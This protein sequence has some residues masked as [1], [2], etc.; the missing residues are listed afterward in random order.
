VITPLRGQWFTSQEDNKNKMEL[1]HDS[2]RRASVLKL[3]RRD[4]L[5]AMLT[6]GLA[7]VM[8]ST[9]AQATIKTGAQGLTAGPVQIPVA[10]RSIPA[11]RALP[12]TGKSFPVVLVV[13]EIYGVN[14]HLCDVCRRLAKLGYLAIAPQL[15]ARQ[16][17]PA[18]LASAVEIVETIVA[19]VPDAQVMDDLDAATT[20]AGKNGGDSA[21]LGITGCG[22]GGRI[23]W[24]YAAHNPTLKAGVA[25]YGPL[26]GTADDLRPKHPIDLAKA[27]KA[28]VLGLYGGNDPSIPM[29]AVEMMR[30]ALKAAGS[31]SEIMIY[32]D[33]PHGFFADYRSS[34]RKQPAQDGW[35][36]MQEWFKRHG[37]A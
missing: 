25:W 11:Y 3:P 30:E 29:E 24:L 5:A 32:P 33:A 12:N 23:V 15:Y 18:K 10:G 1:D 27:L 6:A 17:D 34:Y 20:W 7:A 9:A 19:R 14:E 28:P 35:K 22:W 37:V 16:G 31:K 8:R 36:R 13:Q 21:R 26:T 2:R 4:F